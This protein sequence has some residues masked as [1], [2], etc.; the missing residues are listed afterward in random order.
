MKK[1]ISL[2]LCMMLLVCMITNVAFA[3][4]SSTETSSGGS[5]SSSSSSSSGN[6]GGVGGGT[7]SSGGS[8]STV[9]TE[10]LPNEYVARVGDNFITVDD[11]QFEGDVPIELYENEIFSPLRLISEALEATVDWN[12]D[13]QEAIF[14]IGDKEIVAGVNDGTCVLIDG[15][16]YVKVEYIFNEFLSENYDIDVTQNEVVAYKKTVI[17]TT[18]CGEN[19]IWTFDEDI[20]TLTISGT[21]KMYDFRD[22]NIDDDN[23]FLPPWNEYD[24]QIESVIISDGVENIGN[25][26]FSD[27][28]QLTAVSIGADVADIGDS[29]FSGCTALENITIPS[30]VKSIG[31]YAFGGFDG[32]RNVYITDLAS[33][34]NT[35]FS[36]A[37]ILWNLYLNDSLVTNLEIPSEIE[38]VKSYTFSG[39]QSI[40]EVTIGENVTSIGGNAFSDCTLLENITLGENVTSIG[41]EVFDETA[42]YNEESN[43]SNNMLMLDDWIVASDD[44][45][46]VLIIPDNCKGIAAD[47]FRNSN[48]TDIVFSD[49]T[50][51]ICEN[52]FTG[53]K[54]LI[55]LIFPEGVLYIGDGAFMWCDNL[56]AVSIADSVTHI[57]DNAFWSNENLEFVKFGNGLTNLDIDTVLRSCENIKTLIIPT[58]IQSIDWWNRVEESES[59]ADIYYESD[60]ADWLEIEMDYIPNAE[61]HYNYKDSYNAVT[62]ITLNKSNVAL[63]ARQSTLLMAN[64]TPENATFPQIHWVSSDINVVTVDNKGLVTAVGEGTAKISAASFADNVVAECVFVV[65]GYYGD[66]N[67]DNIVTVDDV[68]YLNNHLSDAITYPVA[69]GDINTDSKTDTEDVIYLLKNIMLPDRYPFI[70]Q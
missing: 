21:G 25:Y 19:L 10:E 63:K 50:K 29:A 48:I 15:R 62:D 53:C 68:I 35:G 64:L 13:T 47:A 30:N 4:S 61:I 7:T 58:S 32:T 31:G 17:D 20:Y 33:F 49:N 14:T 26:A 46:G 66:C 41:D 3:T 52:A 40:T 42:Y 9:T 6:I 56:E 69:D 70:V 36:H 1:I 24:E 12:G 5:S 59:I 43:W 55:S 54:R 2:V 38:R 16:T 34:C 22:E 11:E 51:Y 28:T 45:E 8:S 57:G 27:C 65:V 60:E 18:S 39:C 23:Y 67:N 37:D 44:V